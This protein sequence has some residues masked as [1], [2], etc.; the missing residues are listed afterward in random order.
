MKIKLVVDSATDLSRAWLAEHDIAVVPAFVNF[1]NESFPDDGISITNE[2]FYKRLATSPIPPTTSAPSPGVAQE[3][4]KRALED[5]DHVIAITTAAQ[6]SGIYTAMRLAAQLVDSERITV[7]DSGT[8][9]MNIGFQ[10]QAAEAARA[11]GAAVDGIIAAVREA[12]TRGYVWGMPGSLEYL[13]RSGR[14]SRIISGIGTLLQI[15]PIISVREGEVSSSQRARTE[16]KALSLMAEN[17]RALAPLEKVAILHAHYPKGAEL[18]MK[19]M[20][21]ILPAHPAN[22]Y[23]VDIAPAIGVHFGPESVGLAVLRQA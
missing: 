6:L 14:V 16:S 22:I 8:L 7:Y 19:L 17:A 9:T 21:D 1:G 15:R 5:A 3:I 18:L 11:A 23:T 2:T 12:R 20:S 4:F 10:V 13:R